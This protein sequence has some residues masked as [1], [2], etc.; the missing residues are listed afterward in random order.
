MPALQSPIPEN[1][2]TTF[3]Q[4]TK[5]NTRGNL[6][7]TRLRPV[8]AAAGTAGGTNV[9]LLTCRETTNAVFAHQRRNAKLPV[10]KAVARGS[11]R[12]SRM[13][14]GRSLAPREFC[15]AAHA[16]EPREIRRE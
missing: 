7:V 5:F 15:R 16:K 9:R 4:R 3:R 6:T 11:N 2:R 12:V 13:D 8:A 14:A 10:A 1:A